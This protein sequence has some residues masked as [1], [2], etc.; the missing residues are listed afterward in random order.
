MVRNLLTLDQSA[1][2]YTAFHLDIDGKARCL[3]RPV[4]ISRERVIDGKWVDSSRKDVP[5]AHVVWARPDERPQPSEDGDRKARSHAA[6]QEMVDI[7]QANDMGYGPSGDGGRE[8]AAQTHA[9]TAETRMDT[10]FQPLSGVGAAASGDGDL[11]PLPK[12]GPICY[13]MVADI[14]EYKVPRVG[15]HLLGVYDAALWSTDQ[16]QAYARTAIASRDATIA[17]RNRQ[18]KAARGL[19]DLR[20]N[21]LLE[22]RA[23]LDDLR[24]KLEARGEPVADVA[25][26]ERAW[27]AGLH[28]DHRAYAELRALYDSFTAP[29]PAALGEKAV[30]QALKDAR[31]IAMRN[32]LAARIPESGDFGDIA[33]HLDWALGQI[34]AQSPQ[35]EQ[36]EG[37]HADQA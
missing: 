24:A 5:Y 19:A 22:L 33:Q 18:L 28:A 32:V 30:L 14:Q 17:E 35:G 6:I 7:A 26:I 31:D 3:T 34:A 9:K 2:L 37:G 21:E 12:V 25:A 16:M 27:K 15:K 4:M 23:Q 13:A 36:Q 11:P 1:P 8:G 10:G 20:F 29:Q